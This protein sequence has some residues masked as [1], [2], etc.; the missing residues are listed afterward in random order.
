MLYDVSHAQILLNVTLVRLNGVSMADPKP[1]NTKRQ[2]EAG[3]AARAETRRLLLE[4][5]AEEFA[6][7]GYLGTTVGNI[8][9][10]ASVSVQTL[11]SAWG[12]KLALLR[13]FLE[14]ALTGLPDGISTGHGVD[15]HLTLTAEADP[16]A[17]IASI[18]SLYRRVVERAALGWQLYRD[19]AA[20]DSE[21]AADWHR[22]QTLR[23]ETFQR[24][25]ARIPM[26]ILRPGLSR[27]QAVDSA[28]A[29]LSPDTY[30]LFVR[31]RGYTLDQYEDWVRDILTAALIDP[32]AIARASRSD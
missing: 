7:N 15:A 28:W 6:Q 31:H 23:H 21:V 24:V 3:A 27:E 1:R 8:A 11:Y 14:R 30:D 16:A 20:A 2:R 13:A 18:A 9:A 17:V 29:L 25:V 10:R 4:A 26:S 32:D 12:S 22:F 19:A 5:A